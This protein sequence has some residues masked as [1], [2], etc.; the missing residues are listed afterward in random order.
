MR[1]ASDCCDEKWK[2][3]APILE[4]RTKVGRP[5]K[6]DIRS[7]W[8]A[9]Q[10]IASTGCQWRLLPKNFPAVSTVRY[11]F[12]KIRDDGTFTIINELLSV[13]SRLICDSNAEPTTAI[14]DSQS[15]KTTESGGVSGYDAGKKI[16][17]RKRHI[18]VDTQGN[19]LSAGVHCASV[20]DRHGATNVIAD[21][22]ESFPTVKR[23]YVDGRYAG[24]Q[25]NA[26]VLSLEHSPIIEILQRPNKAT[27]FVVIARRW[28]VERTFT[29]LGRCRRLA[30]DWE[31]TIS[32]SKSWLLIA[33]IRRT[34]RNIASVMK[35]GY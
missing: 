6:V 30:K 17:G 31:K 27:G 35:T 29:W 2:L 15:V 4:T 11:Y 7:V 34:S 22:M 24:D 23:I 16:K 13:A 3:I 9:I 18:T 21:T 32:S 14:I 33:A 1:Y 26:V 28:V 25:L 20:Q 19:L 10:Y 5:R 12:Y 8:Q